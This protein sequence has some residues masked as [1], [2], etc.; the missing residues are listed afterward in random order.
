VDEGGDVKLIELERYVLPSPTPL[1]EPDPVPDDYPNTFDKPKDQNPPL[2]DAP[3]D[4][5]SV[6]PEEQSCPLSFEML[7]SPAS[8]TFEMIAGGP[9]PDEQN[10]YD[11][12]KGWW[13]S[14]SLG[15]SNGASWVT[16]INTTYAVAFIVAPCKAVNVHSASIGIGASALAF[17][18]GTYTAQLSLVASTGDAVVCPITLNVIQNPASFNVLFWY[19]RQYNEGNIISRGNQGILYKTTDA[20]YDWGIKWAGVVTVGRKN[21]V[22]QMDGWYGVVS[23]ISNPLTAI[24]KYVEAAPDYGPT[25][26]WWN[27]VGTTQWIVANEPPW[28]VAWESTQPYP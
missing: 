12:E 7:A 21:G 2:N 6:P 18:V 9:L 16:R 4:D 14:I 28:P 8:I 25:Y 22:W 13:D 10:W 19:N 15:Y 5:P 20:T 1:P 17:P 3:Q 23:G 27:R 26:Q 24:S 11:Q